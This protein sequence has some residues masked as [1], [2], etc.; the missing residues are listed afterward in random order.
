MHVEFRKTVIPDEVPELLAFDRKIFP[1]DDLFGQDD[2]LKDESYWMLVNEARIG[3]CAFQPNRDF[4]D[5]VRKDGRNPARKGSLY[6]TTTGI[7]PNMQGRGFGRLL[8]VWQIAYAKLHGFHRIV[9]NC[10]MRNAA[11]IGLNQSL[12]YRYLRATPRYYR[13]PDD[14]T[15]VMELKIN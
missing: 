10:R 15:V 1:K 9:T 5:D 12:G 7:I 8:K 14:A 3:C 2:W 13:G 11:I 4:R 6:I